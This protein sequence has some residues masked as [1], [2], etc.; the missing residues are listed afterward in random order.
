M[1]CIVPHEYRTTFVTTHSLAIFRLDNAWAR[2][3]LQVLDTLFDP[4]YVG[5]YWL[6]L[7]AAKSALLNVA[8]AELL[9][10]LS[11]LLRIYAKAGRPP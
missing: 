11:A 5:G 9:A 1:V 7:K 2:E 4:V 6:R 10:S 3:A 8:F